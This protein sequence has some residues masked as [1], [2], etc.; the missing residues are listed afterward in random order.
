VKSNK[1][2]HSHIPN[3]G[4]KGGET[5]TILEIVELIMATLGVS[6]GRGD[7]VFLY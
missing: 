3:S 6:A 2:I 5:V 7:S 1:K 4:L